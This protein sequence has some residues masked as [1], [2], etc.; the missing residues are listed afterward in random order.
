M[1]K[2]R[3]NHVV[4]FVWPDRTALRPVDPSKPKDVEQAFYGVAAYNQPVLSGGVSRCI[5]CDTPKVRDTKTH[6]RTRRDGCT[7]NP[8]RTHV[9]ATQRVVKGWS[10]R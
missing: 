2:P 1:R 9:Y 10:T 5:H 4:G 3:P 8:D 7:V 6:P